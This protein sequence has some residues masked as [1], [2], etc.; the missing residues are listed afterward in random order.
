MQMTLKDAFARA[1]EAERRGDSR[2]ARTIYDD[3]LAAVPEHPGALLGIARHARA[4]HDYAAARDAL[5]RAIASAK[6]IVLPA[7]ELWVERALVEFAA[8]DRAAARSACDEALRAQPAYFSAL[9][10]A[11]D[12]ALADRDY[13]AAEARFRAAL[14]KRD[15]GALPWSGLAQALAGLLR[16]T[17]ARAATDRALALAPRDPAIR[18]GA[19]WVALRAGD[20]AAADEHCRAGLAAAPAD[21]I[22]GRLLGQAHK[23]AGRYGEARATLEAIVARQPGD[24]AARNS[25]ASVLLDLAQFD[26]ARDHLETL[27]ASGAADGETFANLGIAFQQAGDYEA[28]AVWFA[29]AV[30]AS[31]TLTPALADLVHARQYL[32]A[33]DGL[34]ALDARLA[35]TLDDPGA[36]PRLSPFIALSLPFS[37]AQQLAVARRWSAATLPAVVAPAVVAA[38][39]DRLRIGYLSSD[40]RD[41][42]TGR[43][44]AGLIEAHD[45]RRVEVFGYGYGRGADS[46]LRRRIVEAFDHWRDLGGAG[47]ADMA[48]AIRADRIDVLIDR[49]GH[50]NGARLGA[51]AQRP[52]TVQ[53]HYMSFP[54]TLG[55]DAIDGLIA[56]AIVVPP[57]DDVHY[58]ERVF[59]LPRCYFVT[60]GKRSLPDRAARGDHGLPDDAIVLACLNQAY[61]LTPAMFATWMDALR[62]APRAVLWLLATHPRAQA[63]LRAGAIRC[64]VEAHRLVFAPAVDQETHIAR[65]RSADLALDTLPYGSHTTGVDALWGGVPMLTCRGSTLAGRVGASLLAAVGLSELVTED[66]D[67]YRERLVELVT[68]PERLR[69]HAAHLERGRNTFPLFDTRAFAGDFER[70]LADAYAE[71]SAA[72]PGRARS[73]QTIGRIS[74]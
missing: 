19:A 66:V 65:L 36:D 49:K 53:L 11:G 25:L 3:V 73:P 40:F 26:A 63:N 60:D 20:L 39:G 22:L 35:A 54:A 18:A 74:G 38:R 24:A 33:W 45:R 52:A 17:D 28:A 12:L 34:D 42:A 70:L 55:Y 15:D 8:G 67:A 32:C 59:R 1:F 72:R 29:R 62:E 56:D 9:V 71:I 6:A 16:F 48:A 61:K 2:T 51:L 5:D 64:G 37:P 68:H 41:H 4:A 57:G 13:A 46:P 23:R 44:M 58:H 14:A 27:V 31:P 21:P 43:L 50:T 30:D 47:D 69:E 7:E 10:C